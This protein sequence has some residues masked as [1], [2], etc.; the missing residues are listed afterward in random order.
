MYLILLAG[1]PATGKTTLANAIAARLGL[2]VI[3]KDGLKEVLFDTVGFTCYAE[4][5]RLDHVAN[6][7]LLQQTEIFIKSGNSVIL[8]NNFDTIAAEKLCALVERY[9]CKCVTVFL[10]GET[11]AFYKRYVARD[12]AH[13]RH[14]GH[15]LQEHY[16]PLPGDSLDHTM[17]PEEFDE[18]FVKRGMR[19]V[20]LPGQRIP[21]DATHPEQIDLDRLMAQIRATIE[22]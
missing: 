18:K 20:V 21:V 4:K 22:E 16:P 10:D 13:A 6:A 7:L 14:L 12:A 2:P 8:D 1:M 11:E 9:R 15:I 3:E 5:R 17:T 19:D